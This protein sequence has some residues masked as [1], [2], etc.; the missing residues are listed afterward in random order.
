ME[1]SER[2]GAA[3]KKCGPKIEVFSTEKA[4]L[5]LYLLSA[6]HV[7]RQTVS[8]LYECDPQDLKLWMDAMGDLAAFSAELIFGTGMAP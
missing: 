3:A 7:S 6:G 1:L 8:E 2:A 5:M 4:T